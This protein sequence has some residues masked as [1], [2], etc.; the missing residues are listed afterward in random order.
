MVSAVFPV[1][2]GFADQAYA[3]KIRGT[4]FDDYEPEWL[5]LT[6]EFTSFAH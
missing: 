6:L 1:F 2:E 5:D 4:V 3:A